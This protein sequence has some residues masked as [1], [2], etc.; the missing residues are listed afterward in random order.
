MRLNKIFID[1]NVTESLGIN[2][3]NLNRLGSVVA[4]I[5]KNG[6]GKSR[7]LDL[8]ENKFL[9]QI[10]INQ[11]YDGSIVEIPKAISN[12]LKPLKPFE[13]LLILQSQLQ[14][15]N[16]IIKNNPNDKILLEKRSIINTDISKLQSK[17]NQSST[18][19]QFRK[20][21]KDVSQT[22]IPH[23]LNYFTKINYQEIRNLQ[24]IF[25]ADSTPVFESLFE[26]VPYNLKYNEFFTIYKSALNFLVK[27]PHKLVFDKDDCYGDPTKY[28]KR[29]S[30]KRFLSLKKLLRN[31]LNKELTWEKK[32]AKITSSE[33]GVSAN[34]IGLWKLDGR[35]FNYDEFSE[36]EKSLFAF[37]LLFFLL[38]QNPNL[39]IKESI[40]VI[41]EP[42][43]HLH[44][45]SEIDLINGIR[46]VI[47][48]KGQLWIATHSINILSDLNYDEI[49]MVKDGIIKHPSQSTPGAS[50]SELMS[51]EERILKL[52]DFL[53]SISDWTYVN[54]MTQC[55]S[56]PEALESAR[57]NDPQ[58]ELFKKSLNSSNKKMN[59]LLDFG[60]GRGRLYEQIKDDDYFV[61]H[62]N[63]SALEPENEYH[64]ELINLGVRQILSDYKDL[65]VNT[66]D[67]VILCNVLH[68]IELSV[69]LE[70]LNKIIDSLKEDG[71]LIIIEDRILPKGEKIGEIGYLMLDLPEIRRLFSLQVT[72][73]AI[74][75]NHNHDRIMFAIIPK[76]VMKKVTYSRMLSAMKSLE[77]NTLKQIVKLKKANV[78]SSKKIGIGRKLAFYSQLH[79]NSILAQKQIISFINES[80]KLRSHNKRVVGLK[81]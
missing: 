47:G 45:D 29:I 30:H 36:G 43:I 67:H 69:W 66:Y 55:F 54:F 23:T 4:L 80:R 6:S 27:L 38:D 49:F 15:L 63:Y 57:I 42:E 56:N 10:S 13:K 72:T 22:I 7:I 44:P 68:E 28:E 16:K 25:E 39:K 11:F 62:F 53:T 19:K 31:F 58:V 20:T 65:Q 3:I 40:I 41:D 33:T 60:A 52:S 18:M 74:T 35:E 48:K 9:Q 81:E 12:V 59:M 26:N 61:S 73:S 70:T 37:A 14:E 34:Y 2:E 51:I 76:K 75:I 17:L 64:K 24:K 8:L 21:T 46:E 1:Q 78:E 50:L 32:N 77:R 71:F 5:G 79:I